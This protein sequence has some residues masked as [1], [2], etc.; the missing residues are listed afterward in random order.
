MPQGESFWN[1]YRWVTVSDSPVQYDAPN[2]HHHFSGLSGRL[3]CELEALTPLLIGDGSSKFVGHGSHRSCYIPGP[4]LKGALRSLAEVVGNAAGPFQ[5][6]ASDISRKQA[7]AHNGRGN[8]DIVARSYGYLAGG[9]VFRGLIRFSDARMI[10]TPISEQQW[11]MQEIVVGQPK[12]AHHAFYAEENRRKFYHHQ[13]GIQKLPSPDPNITQR[14]EVQPAP[15]GTL[16][17]FTV[18]FFNLRDKELNLLLY[19]LALESQVRVTL[20]PEAMPPR[21]MQPVTFEGPLRH[22]IGGA[23]PHGAGSVHIRITKMQLCSDAST[24]YQGK[25]ADNLLEAET[26]IQEIDR[27]THSF[28]SRTDLTMQQLRAMLIYSEKDPRK[29]VHYPSWKWFNSNSQRPLKS[30]I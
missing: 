17:N 10:S 24:R 29:P 13:Q 21:A 18:D 4:S 30:T 15:S 5:K 11:P 3:W 1:P 19:C 2:Y 16:F 8:L 7:E 6:Q 9:N 20:S 28:R 27:R 12:K 25:E 14:T 23:K 26:L 22:K